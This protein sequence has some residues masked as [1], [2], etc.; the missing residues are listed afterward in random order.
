MNAQVDQE[1]QNKTMKEHTK[2]LIETGEL[3]NI[4]DN[5]EMSSE[6]A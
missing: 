1:S 3:R 4:T 5:D 6:K 2:Y